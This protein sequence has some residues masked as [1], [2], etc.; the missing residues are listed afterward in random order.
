VSRVAVVSH[1][2]ARG[3]AARVV[4]QGVD[5]GLLLSRLGQLY[6]PPVEIGAVPNAGRSFAAGP[7]GLP[8]NRRSQEPQLAAVHVSHRGTLIA[9]GAGQ[10]TARFAAD[11]A[12]PAGRR[13]EV[14]F[15]CRGADA[16][17]VVLRT[18]GG[19]LHRRVRCDGTAHRW[20]LPPTNRPTSILTRA[21]GSA[22]AFVVAALPKGAG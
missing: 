9:G 11:G 17:S 15:G 1:P 7:V 19:P 20:V 12:K 18:T 22:W 3:G 4:P 2:L 10:G 13:F 5:N 16:A 21:T 14:D 8:G 6:E